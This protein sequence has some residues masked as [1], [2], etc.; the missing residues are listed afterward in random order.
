MNILKN[1]APKR[2]A[3]Y[4]RVSTERQAEEGRSPESQLQ[5]MT[6]YCERR[7]WTVV[8]TYRDNGLSGRLSD[9]PQLQQLLFDVRRGTVDVVMVYYISRFYRKLES[10]LATMKLLRDS[11]VSF[12]SVNEDI[13]FTSKWGK[14]ILNILGTLAEIY[15]DELSETT[16]RGKAQRAQA[17]LFNGSI[18]LGYCN[19]LCSR[20]TDPNGPGYC[21]RVG[22]SPLSDGVVPVPH[23]LDRHAVRLAFEWYAGG[24]C[25]DADIAHK[26]NRHELEIDGAT[27]R[28]QPKRV[29]GKNRRYT[30]ERVFS[31]DSVREILRRTF[32][33]GLIEYRGGEGVAEERRRFKQAQAVHQGQHPPLISRERFE[34]C[35]A[36]RR[37]RG[38]RRGGGT[39]KRVYLLSRI[40]YTWPARSKMRSV[41]N[42]SGIRFYRDRAN[43]GKSKDDRASRSPQPNVR[44]SYLEE[45]V[46]AVLDTLSLPAEWQQRILAYLLAPEGGMAEVEREHRHL[47]ARFER[48]KHL[49]RDGDIALEQYAD[50]RARL[51][52]EMARLFSPVDGEGGQIAALLADLPALWSQATPAELKDLF[53]TVFQRVFVK[54]E[55]IVR[56]IPFPLF[57]DHLD[58]NDERLISPAEGEAL[59]RSTSFMSNNPA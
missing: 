21:P 51:E 24:D 37:R 41:A 43:I 38:H 30:I 14:L 12:V 13:D 50:E 3:L 44:A 33:L 25:S 40:L 54:D 10:L 57:L 52:G 42:G 17:G 7:G 47:Q 35:E 5:D 31:K 58:V 6:R 23:P 9:R 16:S 36:V 39:R 55:E 11:K 27:F 15:V 34:Q 22:Q 4:V 59:D 18:P 20:C 26:L 32:Y 2:V 48:L 28:F 49:F 45:Q 19:G 56:L 46:R 53:E 8:A 29:A 1:K